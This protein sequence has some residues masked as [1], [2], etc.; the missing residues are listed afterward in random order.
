MSVWSLKAGNIEDGLTLLATNVADGPWAVG[1]GYEHST[2]GTGA[3]VSFATLTYN[4]T[5]NISGSS[6]SSGPVLGYDDCMVHGHTLV[7]S[8]SGGWSL[9]SSGR[10]FSFVGK[11][12]LT[13]VVGTVT[14]Y[15]LVATPR[16]SGPI[17]AITGTA[18]S[19][20]VASWNNFHF[21]PTIVY[22][23]RNGQAG[24]NGNFIGGALFI[25]HDF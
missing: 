22:N 23:S 10:W 11:T 20:D 9:S 17:G 4:L 3:N 24:F 12:F 14:G 15:Q 25:S 8:L 18:V 19:L 2:S 1:G 7:N 16:G 21:K 6:F 5:P 13:N